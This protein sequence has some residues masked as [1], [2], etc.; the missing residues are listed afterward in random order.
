MLKKIYSSKGFLITLFIAIFLIAIGVRFFKITEDQFFYYDEGLYLNHNVEFLEF[1]KIH[2][3]DTPKKFFKYLGVMGKVAL[4]DAKALWF[5]LSAFRALVVGTDGVYFTR[6]ISA[7]F[8]SLTVIVIYFFATRF[9]NSKTVGLLSM[10][11]LAVFPS[12]VY[13]SRLGIQEAL[14]TFCF[15]FGLYLYVYPKKLHIKTFLSSIFFSCVFFANYRMIITPVLIGLCEV[16]LSVSS[17][18]RFNHRKFIYHTLT[19]LGIIFLVGNSFKGA[20]TIAVFRW[21]F[22]QSHLA[23]GEFHFFNLFS[24]PYYILK[25]ESVFFGAALF[26][27]IYYLRIRKYREMFFFFLV[28]LIF[29]TFSFSQEKAVRYLCA[30]M[31]AMVMAVASLIVYLYQSKHKRLRIAVVVFTLLLFSNFFIN[32]FMILNFKSDYKTIVNDIGNDS[33]IVSTQPLVHKLFFPRK[34]VFTLTKNPRDLL[35]L[36][37]Q[38][39]EYMALCPQAFISFTQN[40]ER[41]SM[42]LMGHLEYLT[43]K[44]VPLK[45]YSHFNDALLERFVLEHNV[46]LRQSLRFLKNNIDG[47]YG[48]IRLYKLKSCISALYQSPLWRNRVFPKKFIK[49]EN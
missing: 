38:G 43:K 5:F 34:N 48:E 42:P 25:L 21:I 31:P 41:F 18:E 10:A 28:M 4:T 22:Y 16:Y 35:V 15:L 1:I 40:E 32:S 46:E 13:Y 47:Q 24:Y 30:A 39:Y 7:L 37:A 20:N 9:Y 29:F 33:K 36:Y 49:D 45:V 27:N 23:S 26:A 14:S 2:P 6:L 8:G 11:L 44:V 19:F 3:P 17:K 12:H